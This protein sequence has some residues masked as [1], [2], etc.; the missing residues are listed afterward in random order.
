MW[1]RYC[2]AL[3]IV[4]IL[5]LSFFSFRGCQRLRHQARVAH[6]FSNMGRLLDFFRT[7]DRLPHTV[8]EYVVWHQKDGGHSV[9]PS[10]IERGMDYISGRF[11]FE[12]MSYGCF[13]DSGQLVTVRDERLKDIEDEL[14][15]YL[16]LRLPT[17][18]IERL[19]KAD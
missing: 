4:I 9:T 6:S 14:N 11:T 19:K 2:Q 3:I 7:N 15:E 16:F 5:G 10:A 1:R 18:Y 8:E 13:A 12:W 17:E